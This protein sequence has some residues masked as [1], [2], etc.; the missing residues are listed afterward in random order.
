MHDA[1]TTSYACGAGIPEPTP[2][3]LSYDAA[4]PKGRRATPKIYHG[5]EEQ[6]LDSSRRQKVV[7]NARDIRRNYS[8]AAWMIRKHLDYVATFDFHCHHSK[9]LALQTQVEAIM[10]NWSQAR[11]CDRAGRHRF[12]KLIRIAEAGRVVDGDFG[13][14]KLANGQLQGI[15]GDRIRNPHGMANGLGRW[16]HGVKTDE[17]LRAVAYAIH[18]RTGV[19]SMQFEKTVNAANVILHGFF[20]RHDQVRGISPIVAALNPLRDTY[21]NFDYALAKAKVSQMFAFA[22]MR[23][24]YDQVAGK[25][26]L[27]LDFGR[28][29][30][31][32]DLGVDE[33]AKFLDSNNPSQ[34]FQQFN[35]LVIMVALKALDI[36]YSFY[37]EKHTN[38][39]GSRGA[40]LHY[41][42]SCY[43]K[44]EDVRE[45]LMRL[46]IWVLSL[47][48]LND[49]L[50][51]P[52]GMTL[53]DLDFE[54]VP[55]GMPWWDPAKEITGERKAIA[56]GLDNPQRICKERGRGDFF[57]NVDMI[58]E[59]KA[60]AKAK[61]VTLNFDD[62]PM[63]PSG[64]RDETDVDSEDEEDGNADDD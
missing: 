15:E 40:W 45:T 34:N 47:A 7:A 30:V 50:V 17:G 63:Q 33:D 2:C 27:K 26:D 5:T 18:K 23:N 58:A 46:T 51:L 62:G 22:V 25:K 38:F 39:F 56:S 55:K 13:L 43:D 53:R 11:N 20:D 29:P 57:H 8:I 37:D 42:R 9:N 60:Y 12:A 49:E 44:R 1:L 52:P 41:E 32:L 6:V 48:I 54:W 64:K 4:D 14:L 28:G 10:A 19:G 31:F 59:A 35:Q 61:G 24:S 16:C 36:P 3:A 21:E